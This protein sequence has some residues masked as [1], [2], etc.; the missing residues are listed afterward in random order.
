MPTTDFR[1][2]QE[3]G[4]ERATSSSRMRM[5][6]HNWTNNADL[7]VLDVGVRGQL[8]QRIRQFFRS[9]AG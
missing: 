4:V 9:A 3:I 2:W 7:N 8:L 5:R 1:K 6:T